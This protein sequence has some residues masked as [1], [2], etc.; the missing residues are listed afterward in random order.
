MNTISKIT[1]LG[2]IFALAGTAGAIGTDISGNVGEAGVPNHWTKAG[3]PYHLKSQIY[4]LPGSTLTI[5]AGVVVAS[6]KAD[7]GSLAVCRGARIYVNGTKAEP[8]IMTSAE[9]VA[10]WT[11]STVTRTIP[12]PADPAYPSGYVT[13]IA[14]MGDSKTGTWRARCNE[15]GNL[16]VMGDALISASHYGG[17]PVVIG[18]RT[19]TA[20]PDGLNQKAM[21]G[22]TEETPGDTRILYGGDNDNDNSGSISYLSL[23]YGGK[24]IGLANELNGL[25]MGG[26]GRATNVDHV[27]IMNNV[28]DGIETWGGTVNYK[29][30]SVWNIG[31][32]S[33]DVDEG[34]RGKAQF[35]LIVQ[36]YSVDAKQGSGQ[37]D[38]CFETDGAED[39][40]AQP[41]TTATVYNAT[42][43]GQP[44]SGDHGTAW[45]DNARVQ[46]RNCVFMDLGES[47]V[48]FDGDDGDGAQG[49]GY[50]GTLSWPATWTTPVSYRQTI[51]AISPTPAVGA[52][53]HPDVLY[54][55][56]A[57]G[58]LAEVVDSVFYNNIG[59]APYTESD[60]VGVT[61]SG[62]SN[63]AL[64][65]VV[66]TNANPKPITAI[67][68]DALVTLSSGKKILPVSALDPRAAGSA[69]S[70]AAPAPNDGFFTP[71]QYRGAFSSSSNWLESWTASQAF[72]LSQT[73]VGGV[74]AVAD[75]AASLAVHMTTTSFATVD[76]AL[77]TVES[78]IDGK[79]WVPFKVVTGTG[80][81]V[82]VADLVGYD[83]AKIYRVVAQ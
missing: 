72:G 41:V 1:I 2:L 35:M 12:S 75:P 61:I 79:S 60:T 69:V 39:S 9:D 6:Y 46:Y 55:A 63:A 31:D 32:D 33:F 45:R 34:W 81:D 64:N 36:G 43:I 24:V 17:D 80:S 40:D 65:N 8:V 21:E 14:V 73:A 58:N 26:I 83:N 59:S 71:V 23:R 54:Q 7:E 49:Y 16:T 48:K 10:T 13:D 18:G 15:W 52:F 47:L 11:G 42:A 38:N 19:N 5:D 37:G 74:P 67:T 78:S 70:S 29:Y 50:N 66:E 51:N 53:N 62:G 57:T 3:S 22:L 56:Q 68:R 25:S 4:V 30:C 20:V 44:I 28:D 82:T 77:Y 27:E 76:G